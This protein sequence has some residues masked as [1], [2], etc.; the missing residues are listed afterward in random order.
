MRS[1]A[2]AHI[3]GGAVTVR[4]PSPDTRTPCVVPYS[5]NAA[6]NS[7]TCSKTIRRSSPVMSMTVAVRL[8]VLESKPR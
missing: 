4:P 6:S 3:T 5:G 7:S 2:A 1:S 8:C